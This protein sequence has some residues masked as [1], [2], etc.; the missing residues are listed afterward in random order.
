MHWEILITKKIARDLFTA[1]SIIFFFKLINTGIPWAVSVSGARRVGRFRLQYL[2]ARY[3]TRPVKLN[4][5]GKTAMINVEW[6]LAKK[7]TDDCC[8]EWLIGVHGLRAAFRY[9]QSDT[10]NQLL[11]TAVWKL[12]HF[13]LTKKYWSE[14][15]VGKVIGWTDSNETLVNATACYQTINLSRVSRETCSRLGI[16]CLLI[17]YILFEWLVSTCIFSFCRKSYYNFEDNDVFIE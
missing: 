4:I 11:P 1:S 8:L 6:S 16:F 14:N 3:G 13:N 15:T 7:I 17:I 10:F 9:F 12:A 5:R 2:R